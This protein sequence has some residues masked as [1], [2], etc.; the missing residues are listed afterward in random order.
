[1]SWLQRFAP[2]LRHHASSQPVRSSLHAGRLSSV[3][4]AAGLILLTIYVSHTARQYVFAEAALAWAERFEQGPGL[5]ID[6][7]PDVSR[8]SSARVKAFRA[9]LSRQLDEPEAV[10]SI[11]RLELTVPVYEGTGDDALDRGAGHISGTTLIGSES[12][13][14]GIAGHR[15]GFFRRLKDA[16]VGDSIVLTSLAITAVYRIDAMAIVSPDDVHVLEPRHTPSL[17]LVT[18]YPFYFQGSAPQRFIVFASLDTISRRSGS[19]NGT[20]ARDLN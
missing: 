20:F 4:T 5:A 12:G 18:C 11:P 9:A 17:T 2:S 3:F 6:R 19:S 14:I 16:A 13:N 10:L 8:W 7:S 1:M 15:D